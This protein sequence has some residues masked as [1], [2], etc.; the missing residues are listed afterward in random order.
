MSR[1]FTTTPRL[2]QVVTTRG[3]CCNVT[4]FNPRQAALAY[5]YRY[6]PGYALRPGHTAYEPDSQV[7]YQAVNKSDPSD[8]FAVY[9]Y[10]F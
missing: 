10:W 6:Q 7:R 3:Q 8:K 4:T 9:V 2:Y 5:M 1:E